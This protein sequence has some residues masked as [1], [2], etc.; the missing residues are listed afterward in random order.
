MALQ[1]A[2]NPAA[3]NVSKTTQVKVPA[4]AGHVGVKA[5]NFQH[6]VG[7][8]SNPKTSSMTGTKGLGQMVK[9]VPS[10][11]IVGEHNAQP[12]NSAMGSGG[13]IAGMI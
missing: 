8:D 2:S 11:A 3:R 12:G 6:Q 1:N 13:V 7:K 10:N 4:S 5:G 9:T